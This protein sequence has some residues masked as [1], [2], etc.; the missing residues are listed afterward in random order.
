MTKSS[1]RFL[2]GSILCCLLPVAC[3]QPPA[4]DGANPE[5]VA[6]RNSSF[7]APAERSGH[8]ASNDWVCGGTFYGRWTG[9]SGVAHDGLGFAWAS[10]VSGGEGN[11]FS[12]EL[13]SSYKSGRYVLSVW[14]NS[15]ARGLV[16]RAILGFDAGGEDYAVLSSS[17]QGAPYGHATGVWWGDAWAEQTVTVD[18]PPTGRE[19]GK[20]IWIR[21]TGLT[22][23]AAPLPEDTGSYGNSNSWDDVTLTYYPYLPE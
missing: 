16:S 2:L 4:I 3:W 13:D 7:E 15:D 21:L 14:T 12:Q 5:S 23:A 20:P 9:P 11:G 6:I 19:V 22:V 1:L 18:V 10:F 8:V 17:D